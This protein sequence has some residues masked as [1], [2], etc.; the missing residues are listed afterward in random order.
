VIDKPRA[1]SAS[2]SPAEWNLTRFGMK[3]SA[4]VTIRI[5]A[6]V[7]LLETMFRRSWKNRQ[8][9]H[10]LRGTGSRKRVRLLKRLAGFG[11]IRHYPKTTNSRQWPKSP[12]KPLLVCA[13]S[14]WVRVEV[15]WI[16]PFGFVLWRYSPGSRGLIKI[17]PQ[18]TN[19]RWKLHCKIVT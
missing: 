19:L 18:C 16:N 14:F 4:R 13:R 3:L 17:S 2:F 5:L 8:A 7:F 9:Y 15:G 11:E 6:D 12:H 10:A 1:L